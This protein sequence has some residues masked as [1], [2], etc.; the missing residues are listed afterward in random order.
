MSNAEKLKKVR[1]PLLELHRL[2]LFALKKERE[3]VDGRVLNPAE[4]FQIL[5]SQPELQWLKSLTSL[6]S[7]VDA[8]SDLGKI[9]DTDLAILRHHLETLFFK[10]DEIVTSFNNH[11]RKVLAHNHDLFLPHGH[12]KAAV[13]NLPQETLPMNSEEVRVGWHKI[14]ASKRKLLN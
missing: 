5:L 10:D 12:L 3:R 11:Y 13:A 1:A 9:G 8:L 2:L 14:G 6:L 4:W 7:D